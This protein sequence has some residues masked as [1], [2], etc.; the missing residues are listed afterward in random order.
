[1]KRKCLAIGIILLFVGT[2]IVPAIAQDT[3]KQSLRGS[4]LYVGGSGPGNYTRIQD[5]IENASDGDTVLV[6]PGTYYENIIIN[7]TGINLV[8]IDKATTIIDGRQIEG[9]V[10]LI[11][12]NSV[13]IRGFTIQNSGHG[14]VGIAAQILW[15][16][17]S[18]I[19]DIYILNCIIRNNDLGILFNNV[20]DSQV[21]NCDIYNQT[22]QSITIRLLSENI[23]IHNCIIH[24]N[25][26]EEGS[27][28]ASGCILVD[29]ENSFNCSNITICDNDIYGLIGQGISLAKTRNVEIFKNNISGNSVNGISIGLTQNCMIHQNNI[30]DNS[31]LGIGV[32][33]GG[34][35]NIIENNIYN[36]GIGGYFDGGIFLQDCV[37]NII[38]QGNNIESNHQYGVLLLRSIANSFIN[39]NFI[40]NSINAYFRDFSLVNLWKKN[41]WSDWVGFGPKFI[42]GTLGG[43]MVRWINIDWRPTQEPYDNPGMS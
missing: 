39:N 17:P 16:P 15:N 34:K 2:C 25:G 6:F 11:L 23:I 28:Y 14:R 9:D 30:Y 7:K 43:S 24:H 22:S 35:V 26:H 3:E 36:N 32:W 12:S 13:T 18:H 42:K 41:Y 38:V 37:H 19:R 1:M 8:G 5:A 20:S 10:I 31:Y 33:A 40:N 21:G 29:G 27:V 4:W